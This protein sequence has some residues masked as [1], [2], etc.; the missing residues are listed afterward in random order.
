MLAELQ[1]RLGAPVLAS[2]DVRVRRAI[3]A[4]REAAE[5]LGRSPSV[6]DYRRLQA[7][8]R[9]LDWPPDGSLRK[10]LGGSWNDCLARAHLEAVADGDALV[11]Q[12]GPLVRQAGGA[13]RSPCLREGTR[14]SAY[15]ERVPL[16]G[17]AA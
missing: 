2:S 5:I 1:E 9:E 12:M 10:W 11:A 4:L 6:G 15:R 17:T 8:R 3:A 16:L 13:R 14:F 7:E